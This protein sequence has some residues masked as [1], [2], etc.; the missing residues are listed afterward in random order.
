MDLVDKMPIHLEPGIFEWM[1]WY[2]DGLPEFMT[3]GELAEAGFNVS[4]DVHRPLW[5]RFDPK[6]TLGDYY[7]RC[8]TVT[9]GLLSRHAQQGR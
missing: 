4:G 6:E 2:P 5:T 1:T 8:H 9:S 3:C 7:N